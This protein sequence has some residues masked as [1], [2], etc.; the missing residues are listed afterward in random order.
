MKFESYIQENALENIVRHFV[1]A[2]M[3]SI[4]Y[5]MVYVWCLLFGLVL[6]VPYQVVSFCKFQSIIISFRTQKSRLR[7]GPDA[8][9]EGEIMA[10]TNGKKYHYLTLYVLKFSKGT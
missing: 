10:N 3:C 1:H 9:L 5:D 6:A 2:S 7:F 8:E 4:P